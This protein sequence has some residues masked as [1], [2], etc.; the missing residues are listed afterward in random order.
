MTY[1]GCF[2]GETDFFI[3]N[4]GRC[5]VFMGQ[6]VEFPDPG[7]LVFIPGTGIIDQSVY[8]LFSHTLA[9]GFRQQ[10]NPV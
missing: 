1:E 8:Q 3:E 5:V 9:P 4:V 7:T 6:K 2:M 10:A